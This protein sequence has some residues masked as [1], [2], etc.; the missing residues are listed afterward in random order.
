MK[1]RNLNF[2]FWKIN[3]DHTKPIT[4]INSNIHII[5]FLKYS[6]E[7]QVHIWTSAVNGLIIALI[8]VHVKLNLKFNLAR[9]EWTIYIPLDLAGLYTTYNVVESGLISYTMPRNLGDA[10]K[11]RNFICRVEFI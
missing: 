11:F 5:Y 10:K 9:M 7:Y 3:N 2:N 4:T 6:F 1:I 8:S